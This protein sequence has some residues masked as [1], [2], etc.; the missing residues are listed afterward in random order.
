MANKFADLIPQ[1]GPTSLRGKTLCEL[2]KLQEHNQ[3]NIELLKM[4][5]DELDNPITYSVFLDFQI[6]GKKVG[7]AIYLKRLKLWLLSLVPKPRS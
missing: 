2:Y 3:R 6:Y 4:W 1:I 5:L 7:R